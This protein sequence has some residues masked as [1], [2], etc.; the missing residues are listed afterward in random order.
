[1]HLNAYKAYTHTLDTCTYNKNLNVK[2]LTCITCSK[3]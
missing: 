1:M 3:P 2:N